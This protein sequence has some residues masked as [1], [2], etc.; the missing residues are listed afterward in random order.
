MQYAPA[1]K[2]WQA[3]SVDP[4]AGAERLGISAQDNQPV[5]CRR[6]CLVQRLQKP[7]QQCLQHAEPH[8]SRFVDSVRPCRQ[9]PVAFV[10]MHS[11][12]SS[13]EMQPPVLYSINGRSRRS[14]VQPSLSS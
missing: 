14:T 2:P 10:L 9:Q 12:P 3:V 7:R 4:A 5:V 13:L 8:R 6:H 1:V 11:R